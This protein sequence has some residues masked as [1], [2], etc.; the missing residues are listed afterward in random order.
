MS[1]IIRPPARD[2]RH[3]RWIYW[4]AIALALLVITSIAAPAVEPAYVPS[5]TPVTLSQCENIVTANVVALDQVYYWNRLGAYQPQGMMYALERDVVH[6]NQDESSCSAPRLAL[7]AGKVKLRKDK[8][9]RP[10]VLRVNEGDCLRINFTNLLAPTPVDNEQPATR[11]ASIHVTGLEYLS[12]SDGGI[13]VGNNSAGGVVAPGGNATYTLYAREEGT[14]LLYNGGAI[15]GGEGDNGSLGPGLFGAVNV[16]HANAE[17]YRSQVTEWDFSQGSGPPVTGVDGQLYPQIN[18]D[19]FYPASNP[20]CQ[21]AGTP[22]FKML[23]ASNEIVH[24]DLTAIITGPGRGDHSGYTSVTNIYPNRNEAFREFTIIFHD[25]IGAVQAFPHFN[26]E[27]LTHTLASVR[28]AFAINYGTGGAGAEILANRLGVGPMYDCVEC[29][30]E[31]F[32]LTAWSVG[33]PAMVVDI[34]ANNPCTKSDIQLGRNCIPTPGPKAT[35]AFYP[36]DPSNVYHSYLN[37]HVKFRNLHAGSDDHHIFH[38]HAHQWLRTPDSDTSA[39]LDSQA[40]GQNGAFTYEIAYEGSGNRPKTVGDSIFH[41]HLYPHFAQGMWS[42]W[43][44]HDVL[45]AG[46]EL[47]DEG[48]PVTVLSKAGVTTT[49]RALPD[50]EIVTGTPIPGLVPIPGQPMAPVPGPVNLV[51]GDIS[52]PATVTR[53]PGWPFFVPGKAGHRPPHPPMDFAKGLN[54]DLDGG[55]RRHLFTG[56]TILHERHDRLSFEKELKTARP[57]YLAEQGEK[58]EKVAMAFHSSGSFTTPKPDGGSGPFFV[59]PGKP[60]QGAPFADPC[61]DENGTPINVSRLYKAADIEMDLVLNKSG[62]HFPQQRL[63]TLQQDVKSTLDGSR[64]PQPFFF[65]ANTEECIEYQ[66]TNLVPSV[67]DMDDFQV[68]TP[69]DVLS[70]HIHLVKFDVTSSDGGG[71]GWNYEDGTFSAEEVQERILAIRTQNSCIPLLPITAAA[72]GR[73]LDDCPV[74]EQHPF[75]GT[76][77]VDA[78]CNDRDDWLGA[79]TTVQRWWADPVKDNNNNDRTLHTVFTHDHFGPSTHQQAGLYAGLIIE[80]KNAVWYENESNTLLGTRADGGPTTW[81]A[82]IVSNSET[83]REFAIEFADFQLAYKPNQFGPKAAGEQQLTCPDK[84]FGYMDFASVINPPGREE[85]GLPYLF[86]KPNVCPTNPCDPD[87]PFPAPW[88][89]DNGF[90]YNAA[91]GC[92]EAVSADDPGTGVVNYRQEPLPLRIR[93]P[94]SNPP[95]QAAGEPGDLS[96]AYESR[97]DR[98]DSNYNGVSSPWIPYPNLTLGLQPGDPY[99]PLLRAYENDRVHVRTLVGAHEEEHNFNFHG[100]N[101]LH[102][103]EFLNSGY[104]AS[105]MMGISEWYD[106]EVVRVPNLSAGKFADYLYK[107]SA[108][109][110]MQWNGMWGLL[111]LYR[112]KQGDLMTLPTNITAIGPDSL[113]GDPNDPPLFADAGSALVGGDVPI[114]EKAASA[115]VGTITTIAPAPAAK[116]ACPPHTL[117]PRRYDITAVAASVALPNGYITYN[118]RPTTVK[119][120]QGQGP[121]CSA[122]T[123]DGPWTVKQTASGPLTDPSGILFVHTSDLNA[124]GTLK[125]D[126]LVEP[127]VLRAIAGDCIEVTLRN[128]LPTTYADLQGYSGVPMLVDKFNS[129]QLNT[130]L[131]VSLHPQMVAVDI[132]QSDGYN[133][134]LNRYQGLTPGPKQTV[135]PGQAIKYYWYAGKLFK[136]KL[137]TLGWDAFEYGATA[138]ISSD[139]IKH[140]QNGAIGSLI[141]EPP[142][143]S[144]TLDKIVDVDGVLKRTYSRATI[145]TSGGA[146][147]REFVLH[148]QDDLNLHYRQGFRGAFEAVHSLTVAEDPTETGQA[149]FNYRTEP[150]WFRYGHQPN[151]SLGFTRTITNFDQAFTNGLVGGDPETPIFQ[152][153][154]FNAVRMRVV[155]PGGDTQNHSFELHGHIWQEEPWIKESHYQGFNP[156]S[157]WWGAQTGIGTGS[158]LNVLLGKASLDGASPMDYL[159]RDYIPWATDNGLWGLFR[160]TGFTPVQWTPKQ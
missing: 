159:Y 65:R 151:S 35:K 88:F 127:L 59:N 78:N 87:G 54:G 72:P 70:Q 37:D 99:T 2:P 14:Y 153:A 64:P 141:I 144:W 117:P 114:G 84:D 123:G 18:Y 61:I 105:Q 142:T 73:T 32:F 68:R 3:R 30:Y 100:L 92:P 125:S 98:A 91:P 116:I 104:R 9:P 137:G 7:Q 111:R 42:M 107:P 101:W 50:K 120:W 121:E 97:T 4:P 69:T 24:S 49:T 8:R 155:H 41:C 6:V 62:W 134:G 83:F 74:A 79:Q 34:P 76:S 58:V 56:G 85:V 150:L 44:V 158:H 51:N 53:N 17:W 132:R 90:P 108:S 135:S 109:N 1:E 80:P 23:N 146:I 43:R 22:I 129:N 55:L 5:P 122:G 148:Y 128:A 106:I 152:T 86:A 124:N 15:I 31:E 19:A 145:Q 113:T 133:V 154:G 36:D 103:P 75:F 130:S 57:L 131:D 29:K 27:I 16:E 60:Q 115:L 112:G 71:N 10:L 33:D 45:E 95:Q 138:L 110:D 40:I 102:E 46:T 11:N 118:S 47:D 82:R 39:Y 63:I 140:T 52:L 13:N 147:F 126:V 143:A 20:W 38:L 136:N 119:L 160:T 156:L 89:A 149:A 66:L 25:E 21:P 48:R 26:D 67:Y 81:Q 77:G 157:K 139:P 94:F 93:N 28:D 96:F 12:A